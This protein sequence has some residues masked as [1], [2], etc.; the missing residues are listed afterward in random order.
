ME[1]NLQAQSRLRGAGRHS[2]CK[3]PPGTQEAHLDSPWAGWKTIAINT[4]IPGEKDKSRRNTA[5]HRASPEPGLILDVRSFREERRAWRPW[6]LS[7]Q[8]SQ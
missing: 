2:R 8:L 3:D 4:I 1:T 5:G 7:V 6:N